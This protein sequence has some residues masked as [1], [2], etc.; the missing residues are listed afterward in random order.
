MATLYITCKVHDESKQIIQVGMDSQRYDV[1]DVW[2]WIKNDT[3]TVF[4]QIGNDKVSVY[5]H[6]S[7]N[8]KFLHSSPNGHGPNKLDK[9]PDCKIKP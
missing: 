8:K 4:A 1:D 5:A 7:G 2:Y 9:M 3:F 6:V